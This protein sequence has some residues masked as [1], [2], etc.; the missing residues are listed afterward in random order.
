MGFGLAADFDAAARSAT[1]SALDNGLGPWA[2][3]AIHALECAK[4]IFTRLRDGELWLLEPSYLSLSHREGNG[5]LCGWMCRCMTVH[6]GS[7]EHILLV[8][9]HRAE[10]ET[11]DKPASLVKSG[12]GALS[13]NNYCLLV[14]FPIDD[15]ASV[16][17]TLFMH[18]SGID[19]NFTFGC[20]GSFDK[21]G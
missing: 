11:Y 3:A 14:L 8:D 5:L 9:Q 20:C 13:C 1:L 19:H 10:Y 7:I 4:A 17:E 6:F 15:F 18:V 21:H 12:F 2:L 16:S